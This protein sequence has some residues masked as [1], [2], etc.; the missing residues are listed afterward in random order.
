MA[1][2]IQ[3]K[4]PQFTHG[5]AVAITALPS[6]TL[7][8]WIQREVVRVGTMHRTGRRLYSLVDLIELKI[9]GELTEL[10]AMPPANAA[11]IA[12]EVRERALI[13]A[14]A[15]LEVWFEAG[16]PKVSL[17]E[18]FLEPQILPNLPHH[19]HVVIPIGEIFARVAEA[20]Q[21]ILEMDTS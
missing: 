8:N 10:V 9:V 4:E 6:T 20:A 15:Y 2:S 18:D 21:K 11:P 12:K 14:R 17:C 3:P 1:P 5:E 7:N 13:K 16:V 19:T